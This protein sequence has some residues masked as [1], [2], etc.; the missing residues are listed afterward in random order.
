VGKRSKKNWQCGDCN[1]TMPMSKSFC[2]APEHEFAEASIHLKMRIEQLEDTLYELR[3]ENRT[4]SY[5]TVDEFV[6]QYTQGL[7]QYM[8]STFRNSGALHPHDLS[9]QAAS[10]AEAHWSVIENMDFN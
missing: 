6:T 4:R 2:D 1:A 7:R 5:L 3:K 10:Y 9:S 8:N